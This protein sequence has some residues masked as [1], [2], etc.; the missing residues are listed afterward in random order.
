M[1]ILCSTL[2]KFSISKN[3]IKDK[4][5]IYFK[6]R[7]IN[8]SNCLSPNRMQLDIVFGSQTVRKFLS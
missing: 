8:T 3:Q 6:Q 2:Q 5:I 1:N 4:T 7:F